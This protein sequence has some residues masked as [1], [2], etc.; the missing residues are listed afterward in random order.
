MRVQRFSMPCNTSGPSQ[1]A[2]FCGLARRKRFPHAHGLSTSAQTGPRGNRE[3]EFYESVR[4]AVLAD[5][6]N[7]KAAPPLTP[8]AAL[9]RHRR[10][11]PA[12]SAQ[13]SADTAAAEVANATEATAD[14][15]VTAVAGPSSP[16]RA[17]SAE[18]AA[19]Q[20]LDDDVPTGGLAVIGSDDG[21]FSASPMARTSGDGLGF[22]G[23]FGRPS[24]SVGGTGGGTA[25][26]VGNGGGGDSQ[27]HHHRNNGMSPVG[28]SAASDGGSDS[29]R[30][31]GSAH[32]GVSCNASVLLLRVM[33]VVCAAVISSLLAVISCLS[34]QAL[35]R[36]RLSLTSKQLYPMQVMVYASSLSK[37]GSRKDGTVLELR[38]G[39]VHA[40]GHSSYVPLRSIRFPSLDDAEVAK[41]ARPA[42]PAGQPLGL[43][44][45]QQSLNG[46][47][48]HS[49]AQ[50]PRPPLQ[51]PTAS[52]TQPAVLRTE[53][54][55]DSP[56]A[57]APADA[58]PDAAGNET[59]LSHWAALPTVR[60]V[61]FVRPL[62]WQRNAQMCRSYLT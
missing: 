18:D 41:D 52:C 53:S 37:E 7:G 16:A 43:A 6:A 32:S 12:P 39:R 19:P 15:A 58:A 48:Q 21:G 59:T 8:A 22:A 3:L 25:W 9:E 42:S 1:T 40:G 27:T 29:A 33:R 56:E 11:L 20:H 28:S 54:I 34:Q 49:P 61:S 10:R 62:C 47:L 51:G 45:A 13:P 14:G 46:S 24:V 30:G 2:P 36:L 38:P 57:S 4:S 5:L 23:A 35:L 60:Q 26:D 55:P 50:L 17:A 44:P 31:D